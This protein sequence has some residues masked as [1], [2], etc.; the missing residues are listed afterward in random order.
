LR[1]A[2]FDKATV[3]YEV[4]ALS[5]HARMSP[6]GIFDENGKRETRV[7]GPSESETDGWVLVTRKG[8]LS[9][10]VDVD[11]FGEDGSVT[12]VVWDGRL[13]S[14]RLPYSGK[15]SLAFAVVDPDHKVLL[16]TD[17]TNDAKRSTRGV[18][19]STNRTLERTMFWSEVITG[20]LSP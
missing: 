7:R 20:M 19:G 14:A 13:E 3:D 4:T 15:S 11:M 1:A 2:L 6:A 18:V 16:D 17:R 10:P 8:A 12:R 9:F 5:S